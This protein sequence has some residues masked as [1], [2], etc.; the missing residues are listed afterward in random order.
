MLIQN[1]QPKCW[2]GQSRLHPT[3]LCRVLW[4]TG[5]C[6]NSAGQRCAFRC[7]QCT[8]MDAF[9]P[10]SEVRKAQVFFFFVQALYLVAHDESRHSA[11]LKVRPWTIST[12]K[13]C[14]PKS[15]DDTHTYSF[16][17]RMSI[18]LA[19]TTEYVTHS[20]THIF[21]HVQEWACWVCACVTRSRST[22]G[23]CRLDDVDR[24]AQR[25]LLVCTNLCLCFC[26]CVYVCV[27]LCVCVHI[28]F[29]MNICA[30]VCDRVL[31]LTIRKFCWKK[32]RHT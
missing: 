18:L 27:C 12:R 7:C 8:G 2:A 16:R 24:L 21:S 31:A 9:T 3:A 5:G 11:R 17:V 4:A 30:R 29:H 14:F 13:P 6:G 15:R 1:N 28:N 26:V 23:H 25:M 22:S 10:G 20:K 19:H 32:L